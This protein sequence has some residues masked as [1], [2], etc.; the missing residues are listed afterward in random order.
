M[1][2]R[3][4]VSVSSGPC[5]E[6]SAYGF[7]RSVTRFEIL[8]AMDRPLR[9]QIRYLELRLAECSARPALHAEQIRAYQAQLALARQSDTGIEYLERLMRSGT[10]MAVVRAEWIDRARNQACIHRAL[11][12]Q[13]RARA[14]EIALEAAHHAPADMDFLAHV[15]P[16]QIRAAACVQAA[17]ASERLLPGLMLAL[18]EWQVAPEGPARA[19]FAADVAT[20]WA[21]MRAHD[22]ACTWRRVCE[23]PP[24]RLR[25][26]FDGPRLAWLGERLR[27]VVGADACDSPLANPAGEHVLAEHEPPAAASQSSGAAAVIAVPTAEHAAAGYR[28]AREALDPTAPHAAEMA[29]LYERVA[30]L[31]RA[32]E[33]GP[34][35]LR[36]MAEEDMY[37]RLARTPPL[38][39]A[40]AGLARA[41]GRGQPHAVHHFRALEQ[42]LLACQ[43]PADVDH[44]V[45]RAQAMYAVESAWCQILLSY[46]SRVIAAVARYLAE[47]DARAAHQVEASHQ[48]LRTCLGVDWDGLFANPWI[49]E[50][51]QHVWFERAR[52]LAA[53]PS[54]SLGAAAGEVGAALIGALRE[55][56]LARVIERSAQVAAA[57]PKRAE[58]RLRAL[59]SQPVFQT[60][61]ELR[62]YLDQGFI[63]A[64]GGRAAAPDPRPRP[65]PAPDP[66]P[67]FLLWGEEIQPH[68]LLDRLGRP[69]RPAVA[70]SPCRT[71]P[72]SI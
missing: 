39:A 62:A 16:A 58:E 24:Y 4:S 3:A 21:S 38:C 46:A 22:P 68:A 57:D 53:D 13:E 29:A 27:H 34:A 70:L 42:A 55:A 67:R 56:A 11:G 28:A 50:L 18:L 5:M 2:A 63:T 43:S 10:V 66:R 25:L 41:Q 15:I 51:W 14:A 30:E 7:V 17:E 59:R 32:A 54:G 72:D 71:Q 61:A 33:D 65:R 40:R 47:P 44:E 60:A 9:D 48:V 19:A 23:Y 69:A 36:A 49:A 12:S 37:T 31:E 26:P 20:I 35:F 8:L 6:S 52:T 64:L 45:E 1:G